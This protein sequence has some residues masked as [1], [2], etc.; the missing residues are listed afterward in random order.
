MI[1]THLINRTTQLSSP[2]KVVTQQ[3]IEANMQ[4]INDQGD[5]FNDLIK[6]FD[7]KLSDVISRQETEYLQGFS[8]Y[9]SQREKELKEFISKLNDRQ[10]NNNLKDEII[11]GLKQ[12]IA[13]SHKLALTQQQQIATL[14]SKLDK[15]K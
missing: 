3:Q 10:H 15:K 2:Q 4:L 1:S 8:I 11:I 6:D 9:V 7:K 12:Q 14:T 5:A 13:D